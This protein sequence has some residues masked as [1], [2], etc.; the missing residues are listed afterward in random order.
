MKNRGAVSQHPGRDG[1]QHFPL[2]TLYLQDTQVVFQDLQHRG[3]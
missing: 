2:R 1:F 3:E